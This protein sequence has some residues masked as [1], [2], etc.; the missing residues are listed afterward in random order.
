[1][2]EPQQVSRSS[3]RVRAE[4]APLSVPLHVEF[5]H[6]CVRRAS[7]TETVRCGGTK[8]SSTTL[9]RKSIWLWYWAITSCCRAQC[10]TASTLSPS[11]GVVSYPCRSVGCHASS[12]RLDTYSLPCKR[13]FVFGSR[14]YHHRLSTVQHCAWRALSTLK[15][16]R[17]SFLCSEESTLS[18][19]EPGRWPLRPGLR[20]ILPPSR[21]VQPEG[22]FET[23]RMFFFPFP[24]RVHCGFIEPQVFLP[25]QGCKTGHFCQ[26]R[27]QRHEVN[28]SPPHQ[29]LHLH[30]R[31]S[32]ET[33]P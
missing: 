1:M 17:M 8:D 12:T 9:S 7:R 25:R 4:D 11:H 13:K 2:S 5:S 28:R 15:Y 21:I 20:A 10:Q 3:S 33:L 26:Q 24:D 32:T 19:N 14:Q 29:I 16:R 22:R 30:G 23:C 6:C 18:M 31:G 27:K